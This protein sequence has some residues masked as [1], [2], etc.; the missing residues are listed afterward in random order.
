[1]EVAI[2]NKLLNGEFNEDYITAIKEL[3][4]ASPGSFFSQWTVEIGYQNDDFLKG[5][6]SFRFS[7]FD[8]KETLIIS[9]RREDLIEFIYYK[10]TK[11]GGSGSKFVSSTELVI[12]EPELT[13]EQIEN[14]KKDN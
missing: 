4:E 14:L 2:L 13:I 11:E 6:V 8:R 5:G 10:K 1:M 7:S 12:E 9:M 3:L